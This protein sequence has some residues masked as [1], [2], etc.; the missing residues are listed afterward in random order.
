VIRDGSDALPKAFAA[1]LG[2]RVR[3]DVP[4]VRLE[5]SAR[6]VTVATARE[7]FNADYAI[8]TLPFSVLRG[9]EVSPPFSPAK[10][11]AIEELRYTSV[12]RICLQFKRKIWTAEQLYFLT[13]TDLPLTWMYEQTINQPGARGILEAQAVGP[14]ARRL[15]AMPEVERIKFALSQLERIFPGAGAAYE[16]GTSVAWDVEPW[17]R[18]AFAYFAPHQLSMMQPVLA[19][20]EG[21]VLCAGDH[22]SAWPG[23]MQGAL[24]SGLA[25]AQA[26]G[27]A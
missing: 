26:V 12:L 14:H 3:Y 20:P 2:D 4:V 13:T 23:W 18:G 22:T 25:A 7:R 6:A 15:A 19:R 16:R 27:I 5:H 21:R 10:R 9:V 11:V 24:A 1:A 8:C 17:A